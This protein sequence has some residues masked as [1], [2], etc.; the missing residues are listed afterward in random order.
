[1]IV[2]C[3][4]Q[5]RPRQEALQCA[6]CNRWQH[7]VCQTGITRQD[8]RRLVKGELEP[9]EWFCCI[10]SILQDDQPNQHS[11]YGPP[12]A[13]S[14]T[15][16]EGQEELP[17]EDRN[18]NVSLPID[19]VREEPMETSLPVDIPVEVLD[20]QPTTFEVLPSASRRG[21]DLLADSHGYTYCIKRST[22]SST[23]WRCSQ[24]G[25]KCLATDSQRD[26]SFERGPRPHNHDG[27]PGA[28]LRC[29]TRAMVCNIIKGS[30]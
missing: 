12:A 14:S 19:D 7:R 27:D 29:K 24:Y 18:F 11:D 5:V 28:R 8:Y 21:C 20:D 2:F 9:L 6:G 4:K 25:K 17:A 23:S 30:S 1:M 3:S 15:T 22:S 13:E 10:C 16:S 26:Q